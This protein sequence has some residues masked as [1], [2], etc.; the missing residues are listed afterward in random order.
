ML[1]YSSAKTVTIEAFRDVLIR[2]SLGE[3]RPVNDIEQLQGMIEHADLMVSC[4]SDNLLVGI[5]RSVT[6]FHY[7]CY[8]SD[9]AVDQEFQKRGIGK[10][11]IDETRQRLETS[12]KIMLLSA[13]GAVEYYPHIGFEKHPSAWVLS[14]DGQ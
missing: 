12:C 9:L 11:L 13:P 4:W 1:V 10:K 14:A 5:A 6:D 7:C 3:R 2:S 8:L